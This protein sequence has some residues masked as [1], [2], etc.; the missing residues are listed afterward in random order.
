LFDMFLKAFIDVDISVPINTEFVFFI[1]SIAYLPLENILYS[2][3]MF[4]ITIS[5]I[6]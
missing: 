5:Y 2:T 3:I 1:E 6:L 4:Y